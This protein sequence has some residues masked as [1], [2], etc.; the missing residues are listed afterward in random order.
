MDHKRTN[1]TGA[2]TPN[3]IRQLWES[4]ALICQGKPEVFN[5][6]MNVYSRVSLTVSS[7]LKDDNLNVLMVYDVMVY[8]NAGELFGFLSSCGVMDR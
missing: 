8:N 2:G 1:M 4:Y 5:I 6:Y 3:R 7:K